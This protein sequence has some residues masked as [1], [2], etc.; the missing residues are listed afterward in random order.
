[1]LQQPRNYTSLKNKV[2][3][4]GLK[5]LFAICMFSFSSSLFAQSEFEDDVDDVGTPE[6]P[7]D[8]YVKTG[9]VIAVL[10]GAF[11][12]YRRVQKVD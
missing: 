10:I 1:M 2:M 8:N 9:A 4:K 11:V 12:S 6:T 5:F 7:I 3:K